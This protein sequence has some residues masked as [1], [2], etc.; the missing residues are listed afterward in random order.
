MI[1]R[2]LSSIGIKAEAFL[3]HYSPRIVYSI[4]LANNTNE[5]LLGFD[6][7]VDYGYDLN[8]PRVVQQETQK[9]IDYWYDR[10]LTTRL[11]S[12][13][14]EQRLNDFN[15]ENILLGNI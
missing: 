1:S 15:I 10:W 14:I 2:G 8:N 5:Y 4:N 11:T 9:L 3:K 12:V 6:K 7:E 13:D